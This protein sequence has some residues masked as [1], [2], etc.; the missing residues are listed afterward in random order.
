MPGNILLK[1]IEECISE[2]LNFDDNTKNVQQYI[3]ETPLKLQ[4]RVKN[5]K[6]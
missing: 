5:S 2:R 6:T 1:S 4:I 3:S